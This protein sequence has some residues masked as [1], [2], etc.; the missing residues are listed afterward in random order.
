MFISTQEQQ[1]IDKNKK[2]FDLGSI[3]AKNAHNVALLRYAK[4]K[5]S[6]VSGSVAQL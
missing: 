1:T 4:S 3:N 5:Y 2:S 6:A